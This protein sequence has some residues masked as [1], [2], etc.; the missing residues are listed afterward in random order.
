MVKIKKKSSQIQTS[1]VKI[2]M[3]VWR[4]IQNQNAPVGS[5]NEFHGI[6]E[7]MSDINLIVKR[8]TLT[9]VPLFNV[10]VYNIGVPNRV[11]YQLVLLFLFMFSTAYGGLTAF[12]KQP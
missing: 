5:R 6:V 1:A 4:Q 12:T 10:S 7:H 11:E 9:S 8:N 3:F 2:K